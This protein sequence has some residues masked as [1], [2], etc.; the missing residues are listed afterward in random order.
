MAD[1]KAKEA[2]AKLHIIELQKGNE[3]KK[4]QLTKLKTEVIKAKT[5]KDKSQ[6]ITSN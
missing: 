2:K 5:S 6:I 3:E 4:G 1:E